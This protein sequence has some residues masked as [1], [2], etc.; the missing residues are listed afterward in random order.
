MLLRNVA[1]KS[2]DEVHGGDGLLNEFIIFVAVVMKRHEFTIIAVDSGGSDDRAAKIAA[3]V[4]H[5]SMGITDIG[6]CINVESLFMITI[7]SR[8]DFF[9]RRTESGFQFVQ[10]SGPEGIAEISVVEMGNI[11]PEAIIAEA[12][13]RKQAVDMRIPL[14]VPAKSME[15]HDETGDKIP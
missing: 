9:K 3:D 13:F 1:D 10:E 6:F 4:F 11:T 8:F 5:N 15:D 14:E 7:A 2:F 12:T